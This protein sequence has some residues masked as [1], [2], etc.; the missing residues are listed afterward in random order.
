MVE[1]MPQDVEPVPCCD[2]LSEN[3]PHRLYLIGIRRCV[4][5]SL[6]RRGLLGGSVCPLSVG[7]GVLNA[8]ALPSVPLF[9]LP[10]DQ[11]AEL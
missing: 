3:G 4:W 8:Q 5:S 1:L 10:A 2:G 7:F 6:S 9:L 11:G